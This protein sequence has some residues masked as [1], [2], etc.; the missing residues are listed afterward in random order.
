MGNRAG[1]VIRGVV[2][3]KKKTLMSRE[4]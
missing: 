4:I 1:D 2:S 3:V